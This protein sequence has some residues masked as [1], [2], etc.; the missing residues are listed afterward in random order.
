MYHIKNDRRARK[1]AELICRGLMTCLEEKNFDEITVSDIQRTSSV[2]RSTFYRSFD[3]LPDVLALLC[4]Q[5]FEEIFSGSYAPAR[6]MPLKEKVFSYWFEHSRILVELVRI[7][8]TDIFLNS[9][10]KTA[11]GLESLRFL[12][13]DP[14]RYDYFVSMIVG[15][16]VGVLVTWVEHGE[17]ETR[18]EVRSVIRDEFETISGLGIMG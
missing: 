16:M 18:E 13:A 1:S 10:R 5:G 2:S 17:T 14:A 8:R 9:F 6:E 15:V 7:H 11:L 12:A 3:T 4:D